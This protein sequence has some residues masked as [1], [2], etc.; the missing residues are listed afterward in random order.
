MQSPRVSSST[1]RC[2]S[3]AR[4]PRIGYG[5]GQAG[6]LLIRRPLLRPRLQHGLLFI[7]S[8]SSRSS[9][10]PSRP[11]S[12]RLA[13]PQRLPA[14]PQLSLEVHILD[15]GRVTQALRVRSGG[16]DRGQTA[17]ARSRL[18]WRSAR[19]TPT[20]PLDRQPGRRTATSS[21]GHPGETYRTASHRGMSNIGQGIRRTE[22]HEP[23]L[24]PFRNPRSS[25]T[26][27]MLTPDV[28]RRPYRATDT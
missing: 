19:S 6:P 18:Q 12:L 20:A 3:A 2:T 16:R 15:P 5:G 26:H 24:F 8:R 11:R 10:Y 23:A 21:G 27:A 17:R 1:R 14:S 28:S 7:S 13:G 9:G 4:L 25:T 22:C